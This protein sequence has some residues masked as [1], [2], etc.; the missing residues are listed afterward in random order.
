MGVQLYRFYYTLS[1]LVYNFSD[2][3]IVVMQNSNH[4]MDTFETQ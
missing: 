2:G 1:T 4:T 3:F